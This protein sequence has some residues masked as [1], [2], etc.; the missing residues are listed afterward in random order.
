MT[1]YIHQRAWNPIWIAVLGFFF[2]LLPALILMAFNYERLG[3]P[4]LKW[5]LIAGSVIFFIG[6][7]Y[8]TTLPL[9][10]YEWAFA[11]VHIGG[12]FAIAAIQKPLYESFL[13]HSDKH[14]PE[15]FRLPVVYSLMFVALFFGSIIMYQYVQHIRVVKAIQKVE[16][17][18]LEGKNTEAINLLQELNT[19]YP[20]DHTILYN[21][22]VIYKEN[23]QADSARIY[24][25]QLL[26]L[27]PENEDARDL[28][29]QLNF[30]D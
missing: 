3:K 25:R 23:G 16:Q 29:Y 6:L 13:D 26:K 28:L 8:L 12:C 14:Q 5:P 18:Y 10:G 19:A 7:T 2:T 17:F 30:G 20:D 11:V 1:S 27:N 9:Q 22:G 21:L 24:L 15:A 4:G